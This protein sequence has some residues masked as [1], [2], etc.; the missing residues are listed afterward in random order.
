MTFPEFRSG[1][2]LPGIIRTFTRSE[3]RLRPYFA[4]GEVVSPPL[5]FEMPLLGKVLDV[6]PSTM[7]VLFYAGQVAVL[8]HGRHYLNLD[9]GRGYYVSLVNASVIT[10]TLTLV[11]GQTLDA[12]E[13]FLSVQVTWQVEKPDVTVT[14]QDFSRGFNGII[15]AAIMDY[16]RTVNLGQ[17][18]QIPLIPD[19]SATTPAQV[20]P[21]HRINTHL[22]NSLRARFAPLGIQTTDVTILDRMGDKNYLEG[23][24]AAVNKARAHEAERVLQARKANLETQKHQLDIEL[25][26]SRF[27]KDRQAA[28][29]AHRV[30]QV[31]DEQRL[32]KAE[33]D[34][35]EAAIHHKT[36]EREIELQNMS[37]KQKLDHELEMERTKAKNEAT[38]AG[39]QVLLTGM[40]NAA[41]TGGIEDGALRETQRVL[42]TLIRSFD[43]SGASEPVTNLAHKHFIRIME[44]VGKAAA[45]IPN[46]MFISAKFLHGGGW[47]V[48]FMFKTQKIAVE[49]GRDYPNQVPQLFV[50]GKSGR[51]VRYAPPIYK[52]KG[53][54]IEELLIWW[55]E[56]S[57]YHSPDEPTSS[58]NEPLAN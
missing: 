6:P 57:Q 14:I 46:M 54:G 47:R 9:P 17:L 38:K 58:G 45:R 40:M 24:Q 3:L 37:N 20:I 36:R 22:F 32:A 23:I 49:C 18:V 19:G 25:Q 42:E 26:E 16:L 12:L 41:A 7:A 53:M 56:A 51:E 11:N 52:T 2:G 15:R 34:A 30:A 48:D 29:G 13:A 1:L 44:D 33:A 50:R 35:K 4:T 27:E 5:E 21:D 10:T 8:G 28:V 43:G 31:W 55:S 39:L